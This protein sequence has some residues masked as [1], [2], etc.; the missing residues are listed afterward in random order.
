MVADLFIFGRR[1]EHVPGPGY[2]LVVL[3]VLAGAVRLHLHDF[4]HRALRHQCLRA[5]VLVALVG[6][7]S[8]ILS[9]DRRA[10]YLRGLRVYCCF[11]YA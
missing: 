6:S 9:D 4:Q 10:V 11:F 3:A 8:R 7:Q 1:I 5:D 2:H